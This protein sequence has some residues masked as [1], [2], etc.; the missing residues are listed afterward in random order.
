MAQVG[1]LTLSSS[2]SPKSRGWHNPLG[3]S[4]LAEA[5]ERLLSFD[6]VGVLECTSPLLLLLSRLLGWDLDEA[7]L[8]EAVAQALQHRPHGIQAGGNL[9]RG[10]RQW[11]YSM[12]N[13][14]TLAAVRA[15]AE[16]DGN[17][18]HDGRKR[19]R[20][21]LEEAFGGSR[22]MYSEAVQRHV[23]G[24]GCAKLLHAS[25]LLALG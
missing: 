17:L 8:D 21:H 10:A 2:H 12:L 22:S 1:S 20:S 15:A 6:V 16:C 25:R 24:S 4:K 18:Y 11:Q 3:C 19:M 13:E 9:W 7:R 23:N 14:T 5:Q